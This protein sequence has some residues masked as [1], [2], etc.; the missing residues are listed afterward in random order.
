MFA[1]N[2]TSIEKYIFIDI[3]KIEKNM[4]HQNRR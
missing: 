1:I 2:R 4:L 3:R